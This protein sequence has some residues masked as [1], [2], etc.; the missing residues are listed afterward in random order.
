[1]KLKKRIRKS[2]TLQL[3][4]SWL[5]FKICPPHQVIASISD[6][7]DSINDNETRSLRTSAIHGMLFMLNTPDN[8][9]PVRRRNPFVIVTMNS[10]LFLVSTTVRRVER[11]LKN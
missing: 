8:I 5:K 10:S 1:M 6:M 2:Y 3:A 4:W 11:A 9:S 7:N